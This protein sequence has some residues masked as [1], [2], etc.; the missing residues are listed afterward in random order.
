MTCA[1]L[2]VLLQERDSLSLQVR[3]AEAKYKAQLASAK[4]Q[5]KR[6]TSEELFDL[7]AKLLQV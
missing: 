4:Q 1:P 7:R 6:R 3:E 2:Y 5:F